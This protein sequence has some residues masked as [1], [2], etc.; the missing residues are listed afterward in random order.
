MRVDLTID[1]FAVFKKAFAVFQTLIDGTECPIIITGWLIKGAVVLDRDDE[2]KDIALTGI[3]DG[4]GTSGLFFITMNSSDRDLI[5]TTFEKK[6]ALDFE[7]RAT[8]F[9]GESMELAKGNL[10]LRRSRLIST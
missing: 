10:K 3:I 4:D 9:N 8:F 7:V 6:L 5:F 2:T 1:K